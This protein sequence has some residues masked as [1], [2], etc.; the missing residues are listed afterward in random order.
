MLDKIFNYH[1]SG[2]VVPDNF[3]VLITSDNIER[4]LEKIRTDRQHYRDT[5]PDDIAEIEE[6]ADKLG[7]MSKE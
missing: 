2:R 6:L 5:H 7:S 1:E 4:H 3:G